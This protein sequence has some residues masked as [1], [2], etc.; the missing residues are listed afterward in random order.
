VCNSGYNYF[1][2]KY[3]N[4]TTLIALLLD[5][6]LGLGLEGCVVVNITGQR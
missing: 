6:I 4:S 3:A 1:A 5:V 2:V